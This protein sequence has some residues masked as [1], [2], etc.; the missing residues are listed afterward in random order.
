MKAW[1][2]GR[3]ITN[4]TELDWWQ[5]VQHPGSKVRVAATHSLLWL[6]LLQL[7]LPLCISDAWLAK[8]LTVSCSSA[9]AAV[10]RVHPGQMLLLLRIA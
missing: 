1:F 4:V 3:G 6:R 7:L 5:E 10:H 9:G 8:E 2:S